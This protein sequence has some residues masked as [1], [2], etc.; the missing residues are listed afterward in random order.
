MKHLRVLEYLLHVIHSRARNTGRLQ[1]RN[2]FV[3]AMA[4]D[5]G[6]ENLIDRIAIFDARGKRAE[7]RVFQ[8]VRSSENLKKWQE[9]GVIA[10]TDHNH[11]IHGCAYLVWNDLRML[12]S[13]SL[14]DLSGYQILQGRVDTKS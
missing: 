1:P 8:E 5:L 2:E 4:A 13:P 10:G 12:R 9:D 14:P 11:P 6:V 3:R 7:S